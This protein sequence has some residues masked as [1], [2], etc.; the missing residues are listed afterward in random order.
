MADGHQQRPSA[1]VASLQGIPTFNQKVGTRITWFRLLI[2]QGGMVRSC[3]LFVY[4]VQ[5]LLMAS[6]SL[7]VGVSICPAKTCI[8]QATTTDQ[9]H[10]YQGKG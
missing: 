9:S 8:I 6:P 4:F 1:H 2:T 7:Y 5:P 10:I 3:P